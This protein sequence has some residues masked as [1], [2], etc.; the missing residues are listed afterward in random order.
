VLGGGDTGMDCN[1]TAIRQGAASVTCT[2]RRDEANMPGSR[3]DYRNSKEEGVTFLFNAQP[4]EIVGN[5][6]VEGVKM[7]ET[8]LTE[9]D[10]RGRRVPE[11][12]PGTERTVPAD[13]VIIAFG[14]LPNPPDWFASPQNRSGDSRR[15]IPRSSRAA[16]W[17][18]APIL[19]SPRCSKGARRRRASCAK[20]AC[21]LSGQ[22]FPDPGFQGLY[23][24]TAQ[25]ARDDF[26]VRI[27][28]ICQR[29]PEHSA[30]EF[31]ERRIA[32]DDRI[33]ERGL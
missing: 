8:R 26:S 20:S 29:Q 19:S 32:Q 12:V 27:D 9:P 25:I 3:R 22:Q 18:E 31:R 5:E 17:C 13:A 4:I 24:R 7:V 6:R 21:R 28:Q 30:V 11:A 15:P 23:V 16:I 14:F 10:R 2:Y 33:S 1:R